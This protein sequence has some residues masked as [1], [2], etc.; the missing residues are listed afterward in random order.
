MIMEAIANKKSLLT[1][2]AGYFSADK[3]ISAGTFIDT[4]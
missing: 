4:F 1:L 3:E 2:I